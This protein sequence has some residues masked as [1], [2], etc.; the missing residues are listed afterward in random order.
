MFIA[1]GE[2]LTSGEN[3]YGQLGY[4]RDLTPSTADHTPL[5]DRLPQAVMALRDME[6]TKIACGDF[7]C[8]ASCKGTYCAVQVPCQ[9][10]L[11]QPSYLTN[12]LS[13]R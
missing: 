10:T 4:R 2:I 6:V 3:T 8:I 9:F 7:F 1:S 13:C 5:Q 11:Y 12:Q